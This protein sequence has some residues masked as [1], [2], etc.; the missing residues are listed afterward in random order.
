MMAPNK[1][2][3]SVK[4]LQRPLRLADN[5]TS[6]IVTIT[7]PAEDA[8]LHIYVHDLEALSLEDQQA[9]LVTRHYSLPR[10]GLTFCL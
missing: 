7:H 10:L 1:W 8:N 2:I 4:A 9:I 6:V 3:P 5:C